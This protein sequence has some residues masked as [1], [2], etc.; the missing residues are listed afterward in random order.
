MTKL[1]SSPNFSILNILKGISA[2]AIFAVVLFSVLV[3]AVPSSAA[4]HLSYKQWKQQKIQEAKA[5]QKDLKEA[6]RSCRQNKKCDYLS[7]QARFESRETQA[8]IS[9]EAANQLTAHDYFMMYLNDKNRSD[10][11]FLKKTIQK[12]SP[13]DVAE[14]LVHYS[15]LLQRQTE[16]TPTSEPNSLLKA[17]LCSGPD[18][19]SDDCGLKQ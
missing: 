19:L 13:Q 6:L 8:Q 12:M 16:A 10:V 9:L 2:S 15:T 17:S 11:Q 4:P 14:L 7:K 18:H 5:S 1:S 3:S